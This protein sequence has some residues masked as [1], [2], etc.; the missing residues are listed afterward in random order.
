LKDH[1]PVKGFPKL[2]IART[3]YESNPDSPESKLPT[4]EELDLL[5]GISERR[6]VLVT[7]ECEAIYI[8]SFLCDNWQED[9][10]YAADVKGLE[11]AVKKFHSAECHGRKSSFSAHDE[12]EWKHY[13]EFLYPNEATIEFYKKDLKKLGV[14]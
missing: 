11:A 10:F 5:H 9:Y 2:V 7:S 12:P 6:V 14:L 8:G 3:G 4:G 1:A 13:L